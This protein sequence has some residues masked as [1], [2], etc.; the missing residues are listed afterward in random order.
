MG[1]Y[2]FKLTGQTPILFHHDNIDGM[3]VVQEWQKDPRNKGLSKAG[4]DR[5]PA[6]VWKQYLYVDTEGFVTLP[7]ENLMAALRYAGAKVVGNKR[8][9]F[10]AR[11]QSGLLL[12]SEYLEFQGPNGRISM[13]DL[14]DIHEQKFADHAEMVKDFGFSLFVKR[15]TV[16]QSKH[17]RVRPRFDHWTVKGQIQVLEP[18]ITEDIL[19]T[20]FEIAGERAGLGDWRPSAKISPGPYGRFSTELKAVSRR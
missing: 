10:K 12:A 1:V 8:E 13:E 14:E 19:R 6:W 2:E 9:S 17:V 18:S 11:S 3:E 20:M 4:D 15:A 16:G 7:G 5:S